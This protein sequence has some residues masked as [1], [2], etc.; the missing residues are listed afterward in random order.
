[1]TSQHQPII[2]VRKRRAQHVVHHGGAWKVAYA[3]FVTAMMAFFLVL[4]LMSSTNEVKHAIA[5]YFNDP[6]GYTRRIG[7]G[8]VGQGHAIALNKNQMTQLKEKLE[9]AL[10]QQMK[11]DQLKE[12]VKMSVSSEGLRIELIESAHGMFFENGRASPTQEGIVVLEALSRELQRFTNPLLI[13]GHTDSKP[14]HNELYSNWELSVDRANVAR[15]IMQAN[16][17]HADQI[18]QVRGFA[19]Q[20]LR[21]PERPEDPSNRRVTIIV[22]YPRTLEDGPA[23][24]TMTATAKALALSAPSKK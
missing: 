21:I 11:M 23:L 1:M 8:L 20:Q 18:A 3:D 19:D 14:Y 13:E 7:T 4:W 24:Q 12:H 22:Q 5:G 16:G 15:R 2:L 6:K 10:T 17:L 9:Q